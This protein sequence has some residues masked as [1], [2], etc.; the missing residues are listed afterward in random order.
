[1]PARWNDEISCKFVELYKEHEHGKLLW[2]KLSKILNGRILPGKTRSRKLK[3]ERPT[4]KNLI[5]QKSKRSGA[6]VTNLP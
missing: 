5:K 3:Y 1:M 2:R 6:G 4:N